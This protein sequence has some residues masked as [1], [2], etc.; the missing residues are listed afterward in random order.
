M[1]NNNYAK[2]GKQ[3]IEENITPEVLGFWYLS[4]AIE[5]YEP[6]IKAGAL[7]EVIARV[8]G[9][10]SSRVERCMRHAIAK[11]G[12]KTTNTQYIS[13]KKLEWSDRKVQ[14]TGCCF[15]LNPENTSLGEN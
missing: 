4:K 15:M 13:R 6:F 8:Y 2:Y 14:C 11:S 3:L 12:K 9:T 10:T 7:Y 1:G 5:L